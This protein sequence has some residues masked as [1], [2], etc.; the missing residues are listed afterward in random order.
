[1]E[2][3]KILIVEDEAIVAEDLRRHLKRLGYRVVAAVP[4]GEQALAEIQ[5]HKPDVVLMDIVLQGCLNG[6]ETAE[7]IRRDEHL[8]VIFLTA[9]SDPQ[10]LERAKLSQPYGYVLKPFEERE[11]HSVI[12]I[13]LYKHQAEKRISHLNEVLKAIRNVNQLIVQE[14]DRERLIERACKLLTEGRRYFNAYIALMSEEG[15]ITA[16]AAS[17]K[18]VDRFG[19]PHL[20]EEGELPQCMREAW[21]KSELQVIDDHFPECSDCPLVDQDNQQGALVTLLAYPPY[22]YGVLGVILPLAMTRDEEE[23]ALF[24]ELASDL[25]LAL[26]KMDIEEREH[27]AQE[28]LKA[29]EE[30]YRS[31]VNRLPV[32]IY[33]HTV[34]EDNHLIMANPALLQIFGYESFEEFRTLGSGVTYADPEARR[35][36]NEILLNEGQVSGMELTLQKK[37]G[38]SFTAQVWAQRQGSGD[39]AHIE[40]VVIDVTAEKEIRKALEEYQNQ[41]ECLVQ[42]RTAALI[43]TNAKL[44]QEIAQHRETEKA[45]RESEARFRG[46]FEGAPLGICL[47]EPEGRVVEVNPALKAI[48]GYDR[49][50]LARVGWSLL[51]PEDLDPVR[52]AYQDLVEGRREDLLLEFRAFRGN[53]NLMWGR[54]HFSKI[55]GDASQP[56]FILSLIEDITREKEIQREINLY[57][58]RLRAMATELTMTEERERRRLA[59][60]LHDNIGQMLA[61]LQIKLGSLRQEMASSRGAAHVD[62]ARSLLTQIIGATR[63][64][65]LEMGLSV[66]HELGFQAGVEWLGERFQEQ[67]GLQVQVKCD[68]LPS[69]L[70][71]WPK[72]LLFRVIRELLT[73]IIK[74][75]QA[76]H[77]WIAVNVAPDQLC[78]EVR[79]NGIGFELSN[80]TTLAGFGLFSIA[81]RISNQG[82][83]MEV[84]SAPGQGTRISICLPLPTEPEQTS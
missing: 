19:V 8:P 23:V 56:W 40:G 41:L 71:Y 30:R 49:E 21:E 35:R 53:G 61:L 42:E 58:K 11:L 46:V 59:T 3:K 39:T 67:Y 55:R 76:D 65:T 15:R 14:K 69:S 75:A 62:E 5:K 32:G 37:D 25:S 13:A 83:K 74:H 27:R 52:K 45:L 9:Y 51:H 70:G 20:V 22:R 60:D 73:N 72:T 16:A 10:T 66:L 63:S 1:M 17:G 43:S 82:G 68:P 7:I 54:G 24:R 4:T 36:F 12:E 18:D 48:L 34:G 79:D 80:L 81:E 28:A 6:I 26:Y 50:G 33:Q 84:I 77:A 29:S 47:H 31:L 44:N 38:T 2:P 57:Q 64:L 78:L